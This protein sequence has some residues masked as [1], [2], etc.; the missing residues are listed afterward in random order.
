[1]AVD[2]RDASVAVEPP[3]IP[4][5][6]LDAVCELWSGR[7]QLWRAIAAVNDLEVD[8]QWTERQLRRRAL[9]VLFTLLAPS[10]AQLPARERL[11]LEALPAESVRTA[12]QSNAPDGRVDWART[13]ATGWPPRAFVVRRR[14]RKPDSVLLGALA[15]VCSEA[16]KL[17]AAAPKPSGA[18]EAEALERLRLLVKLGRAHPVVAAAHVQMPMADDLRALQS[19][20]PPWRQVA[21]VAGALKGLVGQRL[22]ELARTLL[23]PDAELRWRLFHLAV[24]GE[25]LASL[26]DLGAVVQS[27]RPIGDGETSTAP[28]FRVDLDGQVWHVWFEAA[29][30]WRAQDWEQPYRHAAGAINGSA[31]PLGADILLI[32]AASERALIVECKYSA[33]ATTVGRTGYHQSSTYLAEM[34][35]RISGSVVSVTVGPENVVNETRLV[36]LI[37]GKI[38]FASPRGLRQLVVQTVVDG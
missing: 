13:R 16:R 34:R 25:M 29:G 3:P 20:G 14:E 28:A 17:L 36:S 18:N 33:K 37:D 24:L 26:R 6:G 10:L 32:D 11:W 12:Q 5:R 15:W 7:G 31:G 2:Q 23:A 35:G 30:I 19:S 38:G 9:R 1:M 4:D 27:V 21:E 22:A 8:V